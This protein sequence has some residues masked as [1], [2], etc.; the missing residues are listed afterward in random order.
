MREIEA[1]QETERQLRAR[2]DLMDQDMNAAENEIEELQ[3]QVELAEKLKQELDAKS[4]AER[5]LRARIEEV[6]GAY[7]RMQQ[8]LDGSAESSEL[9]LEIDTSFWM[10]R[11]WHLLW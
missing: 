11:A 9:Y 6:E 3:A 8:R 10:G 5:E 4:A 7:E 1:G 2:I